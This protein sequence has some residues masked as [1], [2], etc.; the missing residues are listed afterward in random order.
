MKIFKV[1][2]VSGLAVIRANSQE[3]AYELWKQHRKVH[4]HGDFLCNGPGEF[5]EVKIEDEPGIILY[6]SENLL[7]LG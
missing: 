3:E 5:K 4:P 7:Y 6:H 2:N 1:E